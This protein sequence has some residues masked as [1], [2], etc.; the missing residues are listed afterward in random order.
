[1]RT[2]GY[3]EFGILVVLGLGGLLAFYRPYVGFLAALLVLTAGHVAK[4]NQ[5]RLAGLGPLLNL[6]DACIVVAP[7]GFFFDVIARKR[8]V[9][10][11][12]IVPPMLLVLFVAAVQSSWKFGWTHETLRSFRW[13]LQ[14]P[15]CIVLGANMTTSV[16]RVRMLIGTLFAGATLAR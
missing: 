10:M 13:G 12:R 7:A 14:L 5:T 11:P 3:P 4:F 1:M 15:I 6:A 2:E 16:Y 8:P 9:Q